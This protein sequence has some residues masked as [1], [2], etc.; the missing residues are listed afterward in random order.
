[1][2]IRR[3]IPMTGKMLDGDHHAIRARA[4][5]VGGHQIAYL[6]RIFAER[7]GVDDGISGI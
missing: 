4:A 6:L 7:P 1:M 5:D 2:G 3:R